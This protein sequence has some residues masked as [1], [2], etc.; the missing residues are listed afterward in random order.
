MIDELTG[1][2][3]RSIVRIVRV[4]LCAQRAGHYEEGEDRLHLALSKSV[5]LSKGSVQVKATGRLV[6]QVLSRLVIYSRRAGLIGMRGASAAQIAASSFYTIRQSSSTVT[7]GHI[8]VRYHQI[9]DTAFLNKD[10]VSFCKFYK[11]TAQSHVHASVFACLSFY[12]R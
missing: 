7:A 8:L 2:Q 11:L 4:S 5:F 1:V 12:R 6:L 10:T 9:Q 3:V